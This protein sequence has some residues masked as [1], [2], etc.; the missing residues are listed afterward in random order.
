VLIIDGKRYAVPGSVGANFL[1]NPRVGLSSR[2]DWR[3]RPR[4]KW[5]RGIVLHTRLGKRVVLR[6]GRG[7]NVGWDE[8]LADRFSGDDRQASAHIAIDADG[9]YGCLADL[10]QVVSYHAEHVNEITVGIEMFQAADGS[11]WESTLDAAVMICDVLT[12]Y[13]GIQRQFPMETSLCRRFAVPSAGV[14]ERTKL[15]YMEGGARGQDFVGI[16]GHRNVTRNRGPG[17]PDD[18]VFAR[19]ALA[20]YEGYRVD[21]GEDLNVW[22]KRQASLGIPAQECLGIP[23]RKTRAMIAAVFKRPSGLWVQRPGDDNELVA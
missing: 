6:E 19:L 11:V 22:T 13:F 15:A 12:R 7:R 16:Y 17:D 3:P 9:S 23:D 14:H 21:A 18:Q 2:K 8:L 1:D 4:D 5:I 10:R 20:G